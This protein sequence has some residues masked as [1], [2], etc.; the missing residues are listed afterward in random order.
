MGILPTS[1]TGVPP[2]E[3]GPRWPGVTWARCPCYGCS[4]CGSRGFRSLRS[5]I[6]T[7]RTTNSFWPP[8]TMTGC[9]GWAR[10][11]LRTLRRY[12][13]AA[14]LLKTKRPCRSVRPSVSSSSR[15]RLIWPSG[16]STAQREPRK[17]GPQGGEHRH[18]HAASLGSRGRLARA[19]ALA[20]FGFPAN[21]ALAAIVRWLDLRML[22]KD[23][24]AGP[25][26]AGRHAAG[27]CARN[28]LVQP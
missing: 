5:G 20:D 7:R 21:V 12:G 14:M 16:P 13:R 28:D 24:E 22:D 25:E 1:T 6:G 2:V 3:A 17:A 19:A 11:A 9:W 8:V 23:E 26:P 10:F 15:S 27:R 4:D 18:D